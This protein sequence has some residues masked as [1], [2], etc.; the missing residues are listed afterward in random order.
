MSETFG[1]RLKRFALSVDIV[2]DTIFEQAWELVRQYITEQLNP[3]YWALLVGSEVNKEPGLLAQKC[4]RGNKPSFSIM[5]DGHYTG[6]AAYSFG[7][8]KTLWLV[9]DD[10]EPLRPEK[11]VHDQWSNAENLPA[12]ES[13]EDEI[14][15]A[16]FIP[17][18][19]KGHTIGLLDLQSPQYN[20]LTSKIKTEMDLI[21]HTLV[22]LLSLLE[23]SRAQREHTLE[24]INL[25]RKALR[26]E[27]WP[28]LTKPKIFIASPGKVDDDVM[29][30]IL[31][32]LDDYSDRLD[33]H[34]WKDSSA[35][36]NINMDILK[37]VKE[38]Q[39][40]L[41]YFSEPTEDPEGKYKYQDNINVVFEAGMFQS[42]TNLNVTD[43]PEGWIPIREIKPLTPPAAF[44]FAQ[45][46]MITVERLNNGKPNIEKLRGTLKARIENL[47]E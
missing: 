15:T 13:P 44:D 17:L 8:S 32:V 19:Q 23:S 35:S 47:L 18:R 4:S 46:R 31:E 36:G 40:G 14:R 43:R 20:E 5:N 22:V 33:V 6:L 11:P 39:F 28:S 10:K 1:S 9:S 37:Q 21:A 24:A 12:F 41:C 34:Y 2:D 42:Q 27:S 38:S 45:E 7:E 3:T 25:H 30:V 16:V 29:G 26:E